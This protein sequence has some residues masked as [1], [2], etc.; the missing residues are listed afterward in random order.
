MAKPQGDGQPL[1]LHLQAAQRQTQTRIDQLHGP[2]CPE[3]LRYVWE[4]FC[5]L[6]PRRARGFDGVGP[7]SWPELHAWQISRRIQLT[8]QELDDLL[9]ID[10]A[11]VKVRAEK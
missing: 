7:I 9:A 11:Y 4:W 8:E 1:Y 10:A 2:E 5:E 3:A 6:S